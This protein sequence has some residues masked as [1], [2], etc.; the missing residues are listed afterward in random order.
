MSDKRF[1]IPVMIT[2]GVA[3]QR[4]VSSVWEAVECLRSWPSK[5]GPYYRRALQACMD[6]LDGAKPTEKA[7]LAFVSAAREAGVFLDTKLHQ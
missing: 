7:R 6:A 1:P 2:I 4:A 5:K 3:G